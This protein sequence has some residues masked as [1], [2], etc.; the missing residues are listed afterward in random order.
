MCLRASR[1][2]A[3]RRRRR[4]PRSPRGSRRG[5]TAWTASAGP[6]ARPPSRR[7]RGVKHRP[8]RRPSP[9]RGSTRR[10]R[11]GRRARRPTRRSRAVDRRG[12]P[13]PWGCRAVDPDHPDAGRVAGR[14][15]VDGDGRAAG[16]PG[17]GVVGRV[18]QRGD[19]DLR[20]RSPRNDGS[21]ATSSFDPID[22]TTFAAVTSAPNR[23]TDH[24]TRPRVG[25]A[26]RSSGGSR[27]SPQPR[28]GRPG[29]QPAS[30]RRGCRWRGRRSRPCAPERGS[31]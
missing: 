6:A 16:E 20:A 23:R 27:V 13:R 7:T 8:A 24:A 26:S 25:Q 2:I 1:V 31:P 19:E 14:R 10:R 4:R 30:G 12:A 18:G 9:A 15:V 21:S 5:W 17:T 3:D 11:R 28:P 22:G 29:R